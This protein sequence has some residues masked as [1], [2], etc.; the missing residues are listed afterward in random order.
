V[1]LETDGVLTVAPEYV[2]SVVQLLA[3]RHGTTEEHLRKTLQANRK[4]SA[5]AEEAVVEYERNRLRALNRVAE[6]SLVRRIAQ[7]DVAAGYDV[8]SFDG[9]KPLFDYDRFIEVKAS[10]GTELRFFW[11]ANER[12]V[13]EKLGNRYWIYFVGNFRNN[14]DDRIAPIMIQDPATRLWKISQ[15]RV[16]VST[17]LVTQSKDLILNPIT[18]QDIKGFL[19]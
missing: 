5:Q 15:L 19:L 16:E 6:A 3:D 18:Q 1:L 12:R 17:H 7:L 8:E 11:T 10:Q 13:A 14:A 2:A 4:L 9:D